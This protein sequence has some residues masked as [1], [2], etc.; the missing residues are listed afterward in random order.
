MVWAAQEERQLI[1]ERTHE[2][3]EFTKLNGNY[4]LGAIF[5]GYRA[6]RGDAQPTVHCG[7]SSTTGSSTT[8]HLSYAACRTASG[9]SRKETLGFLKR[10]GLTGTRGE[11]RAH[12]V[13]CPCVRHRLQR[14]SDRPSTL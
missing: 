7:R 5:Y 1:T 4:V 12:L 11:R 6:A 9:S 3:R 14:P 2:A 10:C 13:R 8:P